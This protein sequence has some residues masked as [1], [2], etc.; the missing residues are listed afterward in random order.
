MEYLAA[1]L[2]RR[3][4]RHA[5]MEVMEVNVFYD[6]GF[7]DAFPREWLESIA[8]KVLSSE[9]QPDAELGIVITGQEKI[10]ELNK[11]YL[12]R[13]RPTDV[14]AFAL[15]GT[16][17]E[18]PFP[19]PDDDVDHLGEV[20][21][22]VEQAAIQA[23]QHRHSVSREVAILLVHGVLHLIGYDHG[24]PDEEKVMNEKARDILKQIPRAA[25]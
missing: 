23:K 10:H 16:A 3:L 1:F 7:E 18:M 17:G 9:N 14:L 4:S 5:I 8:E 25:P 2:L 11:R 13:D 19:A 20:V 6:T 15:K 22:S 24:E 12:E 21:I